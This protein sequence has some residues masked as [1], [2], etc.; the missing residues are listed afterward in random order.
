MSSIIMGMLLGIT[1]LIRAFSQA[2]YQALVIKIKTRHS[3][4]LDQ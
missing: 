1:F 4:S 2:S 3:I